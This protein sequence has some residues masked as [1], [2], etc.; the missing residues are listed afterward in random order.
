MFL[1][2]W[3]DSGAGKT[4]LASTAPGVKAIIQFDPGG[5]LSLANRD[6]I[7][8][9]D[10][11]GAG[12][13]QTMAEF[14]SADP[15][16]IKAFLQAQPEV[17]TIIVDSIT[18]LA[19]QA[20]QYAVT[21]AGGASNIDVPGMNGYGVRNNIMRRVVQSI[22]QVAG[23]LRKNLIVITHEG[24]PDETTKDVTMSLSASL[25]NEVSL[26]FNEVWWMKDMGNERQIHIRAHGRYKPMK[27]R[28]FPTNGANHFVWHYDADTLQGEGIA[29]WMTAWQANGGRKIPLPTGGAAKK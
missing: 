27:S 11:S 17:E 6:D 16:S 14:N 24:A 2:L 8:L 4:T 25:A 3:G 23:G 15:F 28:V 5:H 13:A 9:L 7:V 22:M 18:T 29:D 10:L 20:L 26:R 21:K 19:F 12:Y 1:L